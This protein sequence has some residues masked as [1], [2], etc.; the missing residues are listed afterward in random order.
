[1]LLKE[2]ALLFASD[3]FRT[4]KPAT[5]QTSRGAFLSLRGFPLKPK[6]ASARL[7]DP[8]GLF[9]SARP[10][11]TNGSAGLAKAPWRG[12]SGGSVG[13][14]SFRVAQITHLSD[15]PVELDHT[16]VNHVKSIHLTR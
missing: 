6:P 3:N 14:G 11:G 4:V 12:T 1:M 5:A 13:S 8:V 9:A 7:G 16:S 15:F 2:S 10:F